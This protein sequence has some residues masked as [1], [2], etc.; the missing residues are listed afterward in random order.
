MA[1]PEGRQACASAC[2]RESGKTTPSGS[3]LQRDL[4]SRLHEEGDVHNPQKPDAS[5]AAGRDIADE[6]KIS[7]YR[8][9]NNTC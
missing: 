2:D 9:G 6:A 5:T 4:S 1:E 8:G 3:T 7:R